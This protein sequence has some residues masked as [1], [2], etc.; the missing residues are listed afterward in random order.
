MSACSLLAF[1]SCTKSYDAQEEEKVMSSKTFDFTIEAEDPTYDASMTKGDLGAKACVQWNN[2]DAVAVYS[3]S[4]TSMTYLAN[5]TV[6]SISGATA[7]FSNPEFPAIAKDTKL[8]FIYPA[9]GRSGDTYSYSLSG[10]T[11][12][13]NRTPFCAYANETFTSAV[14]AGKA[15]I[16]SVNFSLAC[17]FMLVSVADAK[18]ASKS[19]TGVT[20][21]NINNTVSFTAA[22]GAIAP[23]SPA[24]STN[25]NSLAATISGVTA[26]SAGKAMICFAIPAAAENTTNSRV[27]DLTT[28][29]AT[30]RG[31]FPTGAYDVNNFYAISVPRV[32]KSGESSFTVALSGKKVAIA[33]SN[34]YWK[35][36]AFAFETYAWDYPTT[37]STSHVGHFYW[38]EDKANS[39]I[40]TYPTTLTTTDNDR[41]FADGSDANHMITISPTSYYVLSS[42]EYAYLIDTR[43]ASTI[44]EK[45]N[46]KF[47][48]VTVNGYKGLLLFPD[49]FTWTS[50]MGDAPSNINIKNQD[51]PTS[52]S[53]Y[54]VDQFAKISAA[55]GVFIPTAGS[56]S[57]K[58]LGNAGSNGN[59]WSSSPST[60][61]ASCAYF[62]NFSSSYVDPASNYKRGDGRSVRLVRDIN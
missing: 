62:L 23:A 21:K 2:G 6:T 12:T 56:R 33:A 34:V 4:G 61:D 7:T 17:S 51:W 58:S 15:T 43:S 49:I 44:N 59:V 53:S 16:K 14:E 30:Y 48:K 28:S 36:D 39:Y 35:G 3:V 19:I 42:A 38:T 46:A 37:W 40:E 27:I 24:A 41:F 50:D 60:S 55:G 54:S 57:G 11:V 13:N 9:S 52:G 26:N 20:V 25:S 29:S 5:M 45:A 47:A 8:A 22:D 31:L 32:D 1:A 10:Q 18:L